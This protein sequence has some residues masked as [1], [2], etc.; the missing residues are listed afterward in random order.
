MKRILAFIIPVLLL[1]ISF[2]QVSN[3]SLMGDNVTSSVIPTSI[4]TSNPTSAVVGGGAEFGL[5]LATVGTFFSIDVDDTGFNFDY[6][7]PGGLVAFAGEVYTLGDLD[8]VGMPS[9]VIIGVNVNIYGNPDGITASDV[10]F[11]DHSVSIDFDNGASWS[12]GGQGIRVDLVWRQSQVPEPGSIA[13][14]SVL[15]IAGVMLRRRK[16]S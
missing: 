13:I 16:A 5:D 1:A 4:W 14:W 15:G 2:P 3:A 12:P 7:A 11:T 9:A 10:T 6:V 8:W